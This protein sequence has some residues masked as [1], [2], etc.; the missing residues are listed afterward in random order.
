MI[1]RIFRGFTSLKLTL[2]NLT[3]L[4]LAMVAALA[5]VAGPMISLRSE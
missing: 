3:G 4:F 5:S 2:A 1:D